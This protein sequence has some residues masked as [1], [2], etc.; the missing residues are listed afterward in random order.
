MFGRIKYSAWG[1]CTDPRQELLKI[2]WTL[3]ESKL[4]A[5]SQAK[6][7]GL[8]CPD[9]NSRRWGQLRRLFTLLQRREQRD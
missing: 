9:C 1:L 5:D 2:N 7:K 3:P 8:L 4:A 6:P